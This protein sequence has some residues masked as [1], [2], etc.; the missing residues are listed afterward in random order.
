MVGIPTAVNPPLPANDSSAACHVPVVESKEL[1][2][3]QK[4]GIAVALRKAKKEL[5]KLERRIKV[6]KLD[7]PT[8]EARP[9]PQRFSSRWSVLLASTTLFASES[10]AAR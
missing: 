7:R 6:G 8:L 9:E 10:P 2:R 5:R 3:G 1:L 4:R